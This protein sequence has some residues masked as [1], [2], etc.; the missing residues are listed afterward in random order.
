M[1]AGSALCGRPSADGRYVTYQARATNLPGS[2]PAYDEA[3][4]RDLSWEGRVSSVAP[5]AATRGIAQVSD[6]AISRNGHW[7]A[8]DAAATDLGGDPTHHNVFRAG[9]IP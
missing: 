2:N 5:T 9:R 6:V 3:Y 1:S 8:F 7:A 4:V